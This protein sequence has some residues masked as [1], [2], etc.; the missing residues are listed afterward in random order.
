[1]PTSEARVNANRRNSLKSTGPKSAEAKSRT[2]GNAVKHGLC[3]KVVVTED[4]EALLTRVEEIAQSNPSQRGLDRWAAGQVALQTVRIERCQSMENAVRGRI[5]ARAEVTWDE[6]RR[7]EATLLASTISRSP[8]TV[9][10][11]LLETFHGCEWL[12]TRWAMLAHAADLQV[13]W[14]P[15][16]ALLAFDLLGTPHEFREVAPPGTAINFEGRLIDQPAN[17][18][19]CARQQTATLLERLERL[20]PLE[21]AARDRAQSD[22]SDDADP[23]LRRLRRYESALHRRMQWSLDLLQKLSPPMPEEA[24]AEPTASPVPSRTEK[25]AKA[26]ETGA[27]APGRKISRA[28]RRLIKAENR[29]EARK[30]KREKCLV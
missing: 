28:E 3:S 12:L 4:P 18:A 13:T 1:M 21:E 24:V 2:R 5:I 15:E 17:Q 29:R 10:A 22:L 7:L 19:A 8:E 27:H 16:Q 23:E 11:R 25:V 6:D 14:T 9:S 26:G 20:R 30:R